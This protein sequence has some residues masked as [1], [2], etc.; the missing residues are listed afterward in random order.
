MATRAAQGTSM[1]SPPFLPLLFVAS[2]RTDCNWFEH[3]FFSEGGRSKARYL[4]GA[5]RLPVFIQL[6]SHKPPTAPSPIPYHSMKQQHETHLSMNLEDH[7]DRRLF[8]GTS[9]VAKF[10]PPGSRWEDEFSGFASGVTGQESVGSEIGSRHPLACT[11]FSNPNS[12]SFSDISMLSPPAIATPLPLLTQ[13]LSSKESA[14]VRHP[15]AEAQL[16]MDDSFL[17][18]N[19]KGTPYNFS[20]GD[21]ALSHL[22]SNVHSVPTMFYTEVGMTFLPS[23]YFNRNMD[24]LSPIR[25]TSQ[26]AGRIESDSYKTYTADTSSLSSQTLNLHRAS[27]EADDRIMRWRQGQQDSERRKEALRSMERADDIAVNLEKLWVQMESDGDEG[28][29]SD[30]NID[31]EL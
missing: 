17:F 12:S 25:N 18:S 21:T 14:L 15:L 19:N 6:S 16:E 27:L 9:V 11:P 20:T 31:P 23:A 8:T 2:T 28:S 26:S 3:P 13:R 22:A 24:L 29:D 30:D 5:Y 1:R 7:N 10:S 4:H